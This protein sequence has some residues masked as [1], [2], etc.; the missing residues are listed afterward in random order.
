MIISL[1]DRFYSNH[2]LSKNLGSS[3]AGDTLELEELYSF[4]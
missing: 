2:P 3:L 4:I 1:S